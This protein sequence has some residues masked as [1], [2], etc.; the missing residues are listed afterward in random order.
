QSLMI[1]ILLTIALLSS[2]LLAEENDEKDE[3]YEQLEEYM[4]YSTYY[5]LTDKIVDELCGRFANF[6]P[7][8]EEDLITLKREIVYFFESPEELKAEFLAG[9]SSKFKH[10]PKAI[11]RMKEIGS[12]LHQL[13]REFYPDKQPS[14]LNEDSLI[15]LEF[16]WTPVAKFLREKKENYEKS[17]LSKEE[18]RK[19]LEE[20]DAKY[21]DLWDKDDDLLHSRFREDF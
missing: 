5:E 20:I 3:I 17:G 15:F 18:I 10:L 1:R 14:K 13:H 16:I 4:E 12:R 6:H 21:M 2:P 9:F 8:T 7:G 19:E 11:K